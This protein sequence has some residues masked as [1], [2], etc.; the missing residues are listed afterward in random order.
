LNDL[1][2]WVQRGI[3]VKATGFGRLD[4]EPLPVL[5]QIHSINSEALL[6]GT[7]LPSTRADTPFSSKDT[8]L[9]KDNFSE[10]DQQL[11]FF[12]NAEKWYAR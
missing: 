10:D 8:M 7:D 6:F 9:I 5:K 4:F 1:Y 12:E 2:L 11:I 3:R